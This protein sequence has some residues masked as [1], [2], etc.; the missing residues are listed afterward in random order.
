M[1]KL[2]INYLPD[3]TE[4]SISSDE[5]KEIITAYV[6]AETVAI[7]REREGHMLECE[8]FHG[9]CLR[10]MIEMLRT[11]MSDEKFEDIVKFERWRTER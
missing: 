11:P 7:A 2:T 4:V 9:A 8:S 1:P 3:L 10:E 5:T 6:R